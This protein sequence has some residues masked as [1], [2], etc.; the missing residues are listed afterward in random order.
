MP[1]LF[2]NTLNIQPGES[3][4]MV[5]ACTNFLTLNEKIMGFSEREILVCIYLEKEGRNR[6][7]ILNRLYPR[8]NKLRQ[9]R[10]KREMYS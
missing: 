2:G 8:Y 5:D 6:L 1:I 3:D 10:E 9:E 7:N 4:R